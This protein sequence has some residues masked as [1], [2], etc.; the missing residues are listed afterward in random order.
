MTNTTGWTIQ[1]YNGAQAF[2]VTVWLVIN[3]LDMFFV[4]LNVEFKNK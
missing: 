2:L 4:I 3:R 1:N